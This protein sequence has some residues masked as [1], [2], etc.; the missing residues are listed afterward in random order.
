MD[1]NALVFPAPKPTWNYNEFLGE[2]LWVPVK[3]SDVDQE[4]FNRRVIDKAEKVNI[5]HN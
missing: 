4:I 3:K 1:L 5:V 2:L